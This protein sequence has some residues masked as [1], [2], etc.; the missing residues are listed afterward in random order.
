M[1]KD[2]GDIRI[3]RLVP[4]A[5][6]WPPATGEILIER[7]AL[8]VARARIGDS[9]RRSGR[10]SGERAHARAE[11]QRA[12]RRPGPGPHG[13][14][15][16]RLRRR[17]HARAARRRAVPRPA[18]PGR[19]RQHARRGARPQRGGSRQDLARGRGSP[20]APDGRAE[21]GAAPARRAHGHAAAVEGRVR[22]LRPRAERHPGGEP[23]DGAA[24]LAGAPDRRDEGRGRNPLADRP[25]LPRAGPAARG[26]GLGRRRP[27]RD[28]GQPRAVPLPGGVPELRHRELRRAGLGLPARSPRRPAG[29]AAGRRV[30]GGA[31]HAD[32]RARGARRLRGRGGRL[33]DDRLRPRAR[34]AL[35]HDAPAAALAAQRVS[36]PR[37]AGVD[38]RHALRGRR[39]LHVGAQRARVARPNHRPPVRLREVRP[40]GRPLRPAAA[41]GARARRAPDARCRA[42]GRLGRH[43]GDARARGRRGARE[44]GDPGPHRGQAAGHGTVAQSPDRFTLIA[45]PAGSELRGARHP[46]RAGPAAG[47]HERA[48]REQHARRE[49]PTLPGG[50]RGDAAPGTPP[51]RPGRSWA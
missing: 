25:H 16:L 47:R 37:A 18:D 3:S 28:L 35:G 19:L 43:G 10:A 5:G 39:L 31:G 44:R 46:R 21:A 14:H 17:G 24:R 49:R 9:G 36:S 7:D 34:L 15:R 12:R 13:E 2:Y 4:Q 30:P 51:G 26:G 20:G 45:L 33:R 23:A 27:A 42:G 32:L 6:A 29:P 48:P 41:R 11:R 50:R 8:Q 38:A 40:H 1:V 22:A